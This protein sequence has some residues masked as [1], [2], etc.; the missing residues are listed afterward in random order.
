MYFMDVGSLVF[1]IDN[2]YKQRN[3]HEYNIMVTCILYNV[4]LFEITWES[5]PPSLVIGVLISFFLNLILM[6]TWTWETDI[7]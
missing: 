5:H 2:I 3:I 7:E 6:F 1:N 4:P